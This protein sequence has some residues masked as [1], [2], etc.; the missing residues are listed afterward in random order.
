MKIRLAF[1][2]LL[3]AGILVFAGAL[4]AERSAQAPADTII[5]HGKVYTMNAEQPWAQ[6][7]A[8][9]DGKILAVGGDAEIRS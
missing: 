9:H 8:I 3:G 1:C 7:V 6:A 4:S 5:V 2:L